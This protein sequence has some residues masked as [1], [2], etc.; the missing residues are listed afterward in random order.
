MATP[1]NITTITPP[2]VPFLD[3]R[4]GLISREW[5]RFLNNLF[6]ITGAGAGLAVAEHAATDVVRAIGERQ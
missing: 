4:T 2:R 3:E 6:T 1:T 5:Y